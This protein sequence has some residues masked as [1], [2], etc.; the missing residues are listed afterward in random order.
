MLQFSC[1]FACYHAIVSQTAYRKQRVNGAMLTGSVEQTCA[2]GTASV[3]FVS[4]VTSGDA[5]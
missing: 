4:F 2:T 5:I 1:R 3:F